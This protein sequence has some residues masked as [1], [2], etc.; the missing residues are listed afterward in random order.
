M[1]KRH[2]EPFFF[3]FRVS[4]I[5]STNT[6]YVSIRA[7][8]MRSDSRSRGK[9]SLDTGCSGRGQSL[10]QQRDIIAYMEG[11]SIGAD[12]QCFTIVHKDKT[13]I[14]APYLTTEKSALLAI[15][16]NRKKYETTRGRTIIVLLNLPAWLG[17]LGQD[18]LCSPVSGSPSALQDLYSTN[19][20]AYHNGNSPICTSGKSLLGA[21]THIVNNNAK[22]S[23]I[24]LTMRHFRTTSKSTTMMTTPAITTQIIAA[25]GKTEVWLLTAVVATYG[26]GV[27]KRW[28]CGFRRHIPSLWS[29]TFCLFL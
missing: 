20:H 5:Q 6:R 2:K 23:T 26:K 18:T 29:G 21:E 10:H 28:E 4:H 16:R 22:G 7:S 19:S 17:T 24:V 9:W 8:A 27:T 14:A 13:I 1:Y 12:V 15:D 25:T 11:T 3:S